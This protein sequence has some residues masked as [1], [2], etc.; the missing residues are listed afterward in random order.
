[1]GPEEFQA[2]AEQAKASCVISC[3]LGGVAQIN[4]WATLAS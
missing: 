3:A 4:L 2:R 1:V